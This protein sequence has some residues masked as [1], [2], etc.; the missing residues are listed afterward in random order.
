MSS[1]WAKLAIGG[2]FI[3]SLLLAVGQVFRAGK[4]SERNKNRVAVAEAETKAV[5]DVKDV[6]DNLASHS[7]DER[8]ERL[9]RD[10]SDFE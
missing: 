9:R 7:A 10:A 2:A 3:L 1:L 8:R 5:K 6:E 4:K